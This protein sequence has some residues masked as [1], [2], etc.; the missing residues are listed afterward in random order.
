MSSGTFNVITIPVQP[1]Y[2][3]L[4]LRETVWLNTR[5]QWTDKLVPFVKTVGLSYY[6]FKIW[7]FNGHMI[8]TSLNM[9]SQVL[10]VN[11]A[12]KEWIVNS[13]IPLDITQTGALGHR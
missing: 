9:Q 5:V 1:Y 11:F 6:S 8:T 2:G 12:L 13:G 10:W 4:I 3:F 7:Y